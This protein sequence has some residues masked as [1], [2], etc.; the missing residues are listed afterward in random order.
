MIRNNDEYMMADGSPRYGIRTGGLTDVLE[1]AAP[2]A[3]PEAADA[4]AK[5]AAGYDANDLAVAARFRYA[6]RNSSGAQKA[7]EDLRDS[8]PAEYKEAIKV[9]AAELNSLKDWH[10][11]ASYSSRQA[12]LISERVR[13]LNGLTRTALFMRL[14][15]H[16][17]PLVVIVGLLAAGAEFWVAFGAFLA[18]IMAE[19]LAKERY[20]RRTIGPDHM[21]VSMAAAGVLWEDIVD[22]TFINILDG[23][24][25][26]VGPFARQAALAGWNHLSRT[27]EA[28]D[29]ILEPADD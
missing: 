7:L 20:A 13:G 21:G 27:A 19:P 14:L 6:I 28:V 24:G 22:A 5:K 15:L 4:L 16:L 17:A 25:I 29:R 9:V 10:R 8:H 26:T 3:A 23:K 12:V 1:P 2:A 11:S 18:A